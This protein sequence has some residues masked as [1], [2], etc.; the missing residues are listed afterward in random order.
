MS[1]RYFHIFFILLSALLCAGV[2][3]WNVE[4]K[5]EPS[6]TYAFSTFAVLLP[7]YGTWFMRKSKP[8]VS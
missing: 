1:L 8:L 6:F 4:N 2:A 3:W 5:G 7:L